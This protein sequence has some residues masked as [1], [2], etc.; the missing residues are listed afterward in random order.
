MQN[1]VTLKMVYEANDRIGK[2]AR[3]TPV[4]YLQINDQHIALKLEN[5]QR[6]RSFKFRGALNTIAA[7][8]RYREGRFYTASA[9]NHGLGAAAAALLLGGTATV[10]VYEGASKEKIRRISRIGGDIVVRGRD[11]DEAEELA[12]KTAEQERRPFLHPFAHPHVIAGQ[13]TVVLELLSQV[14]EVDRILVPTSGGGL[15]SGCA[16]AAKSINPSIEIIGVQPAE[17]AAMLKSLAK[18]ELVE[19]PIGKTVCEALAGRWVSE[20]TL[21]IC[22]RYVDDVITV[23][24]ESVIKALKMFHEQQQMKVEPSS[25]VGI[26]ALLENPELLTAGTA[27]IISGG[28]ISTNSFNQLI[29]L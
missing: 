12:I 16:I 8:N 11:Y 22:Q 13:G 24:E 29:S 15:I 20:L 21:E 23:R 2:Y 10:F 26:A 28:N 25:V 19:T 7:D 17:S 6:T 1:A 4:E 3:K 27:T 14:S 5:R 18:G 9:G